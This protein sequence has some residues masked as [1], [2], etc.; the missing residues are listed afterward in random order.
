VSYHL[1]SNRFAR[2]DEPIAGG[3]IVP[4]ALPP[5]DVTALRRHVRSYLGLARYLV[6]TGRFWPRAPEKKR[7]S[8]LT[9]LG[10]P[11][12]ASHRGLVNGSEPAGG[13]TLESIEQAIAAGFEWV[14]LDLQL[15][16]DGVV[17]LHHDE[18]VPNDGGAVPIASL[19]L[20]RLQRVLP[21]MTTLAAALERAGTRV[22]Y[23]L[24]LKHQP[25]ELSSMALVRETLRLVHGQQSLRVIV[26]SF[27][28]E[29]LTT[30]AEFGKAPVGYDLPQKPVQTEWLDYA[31]QQGFDWVYVRKE[32][33]IAASIDAAHARGL[34]VM[35][36][37][38]E[39]ADDLSRFG[40]SRPPLGPSRPDGFITPSAGVL[41]ELTQA[42][43]R[44]PPAPAAQPESP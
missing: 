44:S 21:R 13:N 2:V 10:S 18:A 9:P 14:E 40:P 8:S 28:R 25:T 19:T 39:R 16:A 12:V 42:A 43:V 29:M 31:A 32:H 1:P 7:P 36:Y 33:A 26:D 5:A 15:T 4:S 6:E 35:V 20:E 11:V 3:P 27:D 30:V 38:V 37:P 22:G 34:R 41:E 23:L 17:V 24:E